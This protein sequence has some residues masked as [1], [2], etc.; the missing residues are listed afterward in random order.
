MFFGENTNKGGKA[1]KRHIRYTTPGSYHFIY[2][3]LLDQKVAK[4]QG[5]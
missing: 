3:F 4:N 2:Y 1:G 5:C